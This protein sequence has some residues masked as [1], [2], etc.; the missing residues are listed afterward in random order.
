M[1]EHIL[2]DTFSN[3]ND[4]LKFSETKTT[5]LLGAN[6]VI[7]FGL[8]R[9]FKNSE[10]IHNYWISIVIIMFSIS[11][12]VNLASLIPSLKIPFI[13]YKNKIEEKDNLLYF[14]DI[15][16]YSPN[17]YLNKLLNKENFSS[18]E[19]YYAEQIIINSI[20]ALKKF[21]LYMI[22]ISLTTIAILI[23]LILMAI[24]L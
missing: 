5:A 1:E 7:I 6:G 22:S 13:L 8:F 17:E 16:K 24:Y 18:I 2:K 19:K 23:L 14:G 10:V 20:I 15:A 12:F 4:W 11:I 3:I 21:R 9:I